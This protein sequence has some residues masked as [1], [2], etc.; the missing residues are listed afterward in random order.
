MSKG[1]PLCFA[2][3]KALAVMNG[4]ERISPAQQ[5]DAIAHTQW[6]SE[7]VR[8]YN[9]AL[10]VGVCLASMG[11]ALRLWDGEKIR[12]DEIVQFYRDACKEF[13][14]ATRRRFGA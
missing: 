8:A 7:C 4:L 5:K 2:E 11:V 10:E 12:T 6:M 3:T 13:K 14:D 9:N 1:Q